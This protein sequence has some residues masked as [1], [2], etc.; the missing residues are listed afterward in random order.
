MQALCFTGTYRFCLVSCRQY[1]LHD[2]TGLQVHRKQSHDYIAAGFSKAG[3]C[4][5]TIPWCSGYMVRVVVGLIVGCVTV[6]LSM[7][8][9]PVLFHTRWPWLL[10]CTGNILR[11]VE[12]GGYCGG[13]NTYQGKTHRAPPSEHGPFRVT[14]SLG[15]VP[16]N[17]SWDV[18]HNVIYVDQPMNTG[19][20]YSTVRIVCCVWFYTCGLSCVH[21]PPPYTQDTRDVVYTET[22]LAEDMVAFLQDFFAGMVFVWC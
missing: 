19:F 16:A 8:L 6:M 13:H 17:Y 7:M 1:C 18:N 22:M 21:T 3:K 2:R 10:F 11:Y 4:K 15:L 12:H 14:P 9:T 5:Q 20:S